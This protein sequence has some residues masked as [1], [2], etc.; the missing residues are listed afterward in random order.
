MSGKSDR[1]NWVAGVY[2]FDYRNPSGVSGSPSKVTILP[3]EGASPSGLF[4]RA[5]PPPEPTAYAQ[6]FKSDCA[7][8]R[9]T[10]LTDLLGNL[11]FARDRAPSSI[12]KNG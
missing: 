1:F 4:T 3:F 8:P 9:P 6:R 2:L 12:E 5:Y 11:A 7:F 10:A